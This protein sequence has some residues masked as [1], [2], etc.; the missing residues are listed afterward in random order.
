[1]LKESLLI[2]I[3]L[4]HKA[5]TAAALDGC[6]CLAA[7]SG[8]AAR[9]ARLFGQAEFLRETVGVVGPASLRRLRD[10]WVAATRARLSKGALQAAW[11]EGRALTLEQA[12]EEALVPPEPRA[13]HRPAT[14]QRAPGGLTSREREVAVLIARGLTNR[15]IAGELSITEGTAAIH[16]Q[17]ILNK[18]GSSSR[19]QVAAWASEQGLADRGPR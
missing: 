8:H 4:G 10:Q 9:A 13:L 14:A 2:E 12:K 16:V 11:A 5:G 19:A 6:A 1:M 3:D 18:L 17:H 15:Q 7:A